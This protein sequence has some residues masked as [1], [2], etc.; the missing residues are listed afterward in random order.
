MSAAL[1]QCLDSRSAESLSNAL[2]DSAI[3][4]S[5]Q[6]YPLGSFLGISF[7]WDCA[8]VY[9]LCM[10]IIL[11]FAGSAA[12]IGVDA[13]ELFPR[14]RYNLILLDN[15]FSGLRPY[16]YVAVDCLNVLCRDF[17][18]GIKRYNYTIEDVLKA[19]RGCYLW[20]DGV[21]ATDSIARY[22]YNASISGAW[23]LTAQDV[24]TCNFASPRLLTRCMAHFCYLSLI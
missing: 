24:L 9:N 10:D 21:D 5:I 3:G 4:Q 1:F 23:R 20:S 15:M 12:L 19:C 7:Y 16:D 11:Q 8:E 17:L 18:K 6:L 2:Y 22:I 14:D 13:T